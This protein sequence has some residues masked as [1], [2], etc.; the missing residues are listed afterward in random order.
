MKRLALAISLITSAAL[1]SGCIIVPHRHGGHRGHGH[2]Y[3][4][5]GHYQGGSHYQGGGRVYGPRR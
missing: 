3:S 4:D 5:G 1:L 2:H